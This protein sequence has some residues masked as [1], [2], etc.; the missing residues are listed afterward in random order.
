M[1]DKERPNIFWASLLE[2]G[3]RGCAYYGIFRYSDDMLIQFIAILLGIAEIIKLYKDT[4]WS[5]H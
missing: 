4:L 5:N 3:V 1:N 2:S